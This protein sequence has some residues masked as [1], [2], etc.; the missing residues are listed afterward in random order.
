[1][2]CLQLLQVDRRCK[3]QPVDLSQLVKLQESNN[4][5]GS[6]VGEERRIKLDCMTLCAFMQETQEG[7]GG[8]EGG[9][10]GERERESDV[11]QLL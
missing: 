5:D 10:E 4:S 8:R 1:M 3:H 7:E 9:K 2:T 11:L 6:G